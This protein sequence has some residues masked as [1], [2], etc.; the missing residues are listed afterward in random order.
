[1]IFKK[2]FSL[3]RFKTMFIP[4]SLKTMR[5]NPTFPHNVSIKNCLDS[6]NADPYPANFPVQKMHIRIQEACRSW[7]CLFGS[8]KLQ[9][10]KMRSLL[11]KTCKS[12]KCRSG[13]GKLVDP[14][15]ENLYILIQKTC[16]IFIHLQVWPLFLLLHQLPLQVWNNTQFLNTKKQAT[17]HFINK[18]LL[19]YPF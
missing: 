1:M 16:R 6:E 19:D 10:P 17:Y 14:D 12:T 11:R 3:P 8:K 13:Y 5:N 4:R 2:Y 9:I 15:T 7:K 18:P